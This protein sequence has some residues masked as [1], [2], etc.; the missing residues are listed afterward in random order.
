M[1]KSNSKSINSLFI[2]IFLFSFKL[3]AQISVGLRESAL[4]GS[5]VA[6]SDSSAFAF[7]NPAL[8]S[9]KE[10]SHFSFTGTTFSYFSSRNEES[11]FNSSQVSPN[12]IATVQ[13]FEGFVHE[14]SLANESSL[15]AEYTKPVKDG[16]Q[17]HQFDLDINSLAYSFAF[18]NFPFGFQLGVNIN[19]TAN[20]LTYKTDDGNV[21][22]G[23]Y[24]KNDDLTA[25]L[26]L[27]VGGIHQLGTHYRFGYKY[28]S[29][30]LNIYHQNKNSGFYYSYDQANNLFNTGNSSMATEGEKKGQVIRIGHSFNLNQH[31]FLTDSVFAENSELQ[32]SYGF[33]QTFGYKVT[34]SNQWQFMCGMSHNFSSNWLGF[35]GS[36]YFSTGFSWLTN[37][38]RSTISAYYNQN[39]GD[40]Q[41]KS[42]GITFGSEFLY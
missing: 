30:G 39:K 1:K 22:T 9:E 16:I 12:Y 41:F 25:D 23:V 14:F 33:T 28:Q 24:S 32:S 37:T 19:Q 29:R 21:K 40:S 18:R 3:Q 2:L 5:G 11:N 35:E 34:F 4:G 38:L 36:N 15:S 13:A 7:Y 20:Y 42:A 10:K 6:L 17:G 31:E 26:F 8:L 27:G